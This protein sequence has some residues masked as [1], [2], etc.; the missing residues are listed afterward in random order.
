M[1][2]RDLTPLDRD[3]LLMVR[4]VFNLDSRA[5]IVYVGWLGTWRPYKK[6]MTAPAF[7]QRLVK[8][9]ASPSRFHRGFFRCRQGVCKLRLRSE[10]GAGELIVIG[11]AQIFLAP[12]LIG[13]YVTHHSYLPPVQFIEAVL[14]SDGPVRSR[15]HG[16]D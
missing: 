11:S 16:A 2:I 15:G 4:D 8:F 3:A 13:H 14:G 6:G 10:F 5:P 9:C 12:S 7:R 1:Y